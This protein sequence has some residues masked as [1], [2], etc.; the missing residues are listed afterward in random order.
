[1]P[2]NP[3]RSRALNPP[4]TILTDDQ[5][6]EA[7]AR[8]V[9]LR[10]RTARDPDAV[11]PQAMSAADAVRMTETWRLNTRWYR[12]GHGHDPDHDPWFWVGWVG[13]ETPW[14]FAT[15]LGQDRYRGTWAVWLNVEDGRVWLRWERHGRVADDPYP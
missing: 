8:A 2:H 12:F 11:R 7:M 3:R 13:L 15:P 4:T 5:I 10:R 1:V 6:A 14:G 9:D